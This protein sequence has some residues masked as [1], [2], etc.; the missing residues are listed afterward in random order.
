MSVYIHLIRQWKQAL[1]DINKSQISQAFVNWN[2]NIILNASSKIHHGL[3]INAR[4]IF[5]KMLISPHAKTCR[6]AGKQWYNNTRSLHLHFTKG[7]ILIILFEKRCITGGKTTKQSFVFISYSI[8][9]QTEVSW[10]PSNLV[11]R[12]WDTEVGFAA[13][14]CIVNNLTKIVSSIRFWSLE[15]EFDSSLF[16][17]AAVFT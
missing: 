7:A 14:D 4:F 3:L 16:S 13:S 1:I 2:V 6:T 5:L 8:E 11:K 12:T 17:Y 10:L 9:D 15:Y